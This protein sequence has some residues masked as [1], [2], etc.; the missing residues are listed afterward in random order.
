MAKSK[1]MLKKALKMG[2]PYKKTIMR[3][4]G[5]FELFLNA[6]YGTI[7]L[8]KAKRMNVLSQETMRFRLLPSPFFFFNSRTS[9]RSLS[10]FPLNFLLN[11][12][13][14]W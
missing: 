11:E 12:K 10:G 7:V 13:R 4:D 1:K 6:F 9:Y 8:R 14:E 5:H 2:A 3:K